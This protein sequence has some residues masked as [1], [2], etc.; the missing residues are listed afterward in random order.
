MTMD[1]TSTYKDYS[2]S[3]LETTFDIQDALDGSNNMFSES[4]YK[5]L[6]EMRDRCQKFIEEFGELERRWSERTKNN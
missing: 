1:C 3:V 5:V 6:Q 2:N 4:E